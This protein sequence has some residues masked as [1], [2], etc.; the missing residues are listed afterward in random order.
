MPLYHDFYSRHLTQSVLDVPIAFSTAG[1]SLGLVT[2]GG[3]SG[4]SVAARKS[5][6]KQCLVC[7]LIY[8]I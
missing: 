6:S 4:R 8:K 1:Y 5:V 2:P 7:T 3:I